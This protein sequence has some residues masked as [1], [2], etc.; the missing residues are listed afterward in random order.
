[1]RAQRLARSR[2][3]GAP[4]G[5]ARSFHR[6][7]L[8]RED[9]RSR[10]PRCQR[11]R[12][13]GAGRAGARAGRGKPQPHRLS[14][15]LR[16][17]KLGHAGDG[18][19]ED[20]SFVPYTVPGD[21][22]RVEDGRLVEIVE[23]SPHRTSPVCRHF[24]VCGGC[25]LQHLDDATYRRF[26]R[27]LVVQTLAQRGIADVHVN[28]PAV[29]APKT[30]RRAVLKAIKQNGETK[31]GF[32]ARQSHA[33]V[34]MH[35]CHVLTPEL[36]VTVGKLRLLMH[37]VLREGEQAERHL[38]EADNGFDLSLKTKRANTPAATAQIAQRAAQIGLIR[39][40]AGGEPMAEFERFLQIYVRDNIGKAKSVADLFC[41]IGTFALPLAAHAKV[42]A[43]DSDAAMVASLAAAARAVKGLKPLAAERRDLFRR[44]LMAPELDKFDAIVLDPPHAG[45]AA[46]AEQIAKSK[47]ARVI[48]VSCN[49]AS[50]ARDARTL[51]DGGFR[52]AAITPVDQ[53]LWSAQLELA[54]RFE[55]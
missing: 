43:F 48:Y 14:T 4:D 22:V 32:N 8:A 37:A 23:P 49:P 36:F 30:R 2:V 12:G 31:I 25:A 11:H 13:D 45:A 19:A 29:V 34:D 54:A 35:E 6:S 15:T 46:Q 55:R 39:V 52:L 44:P 18:V 27:D 38:T 5:A 40:T 20:G 3:E 1:P 50:F 17:T 24:G 7:G 26:K 41:G 16:I 9:V 53:F 47:V 42:Q 33:V 51:I 10:W 28:E 21:V